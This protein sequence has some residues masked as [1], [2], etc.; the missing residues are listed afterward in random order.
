MAEQEDITPAPSVRMQGQPLVKRGGDISE[1]RQ[2]KNKSTSFAG[3]RCEKHA[4]E[5]Q[6]EEEEDID[7]GQQKSEY[8][9]VRGE[10]KTM[11]E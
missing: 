3:L 11:A 1:S 10:M 5:E 9:S 8:L 2:F 6:E 7:E 4:E